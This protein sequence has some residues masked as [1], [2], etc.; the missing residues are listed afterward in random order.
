M[1]DLSLADRLYRFSVSYPELIVEFR[2]GAGWFTV[3]TMTGAADLV[4][5]LPRWHAVERGES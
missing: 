3:S 1:E 2:K 5:I 4:T